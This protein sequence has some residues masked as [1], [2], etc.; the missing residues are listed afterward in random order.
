M[1]II[2]RLGIMHLESLFQIKRGNCQLRS[3][4]IDRFID[5]NPNTVAYRNSFY[6]RTI[7]EWN[8]LPNIVFHTGKTSLHVFKQETIISFSLDLK[9]HSVWDYWILVMIYIYSTNIDCTF[10]YTVIVRFFDSPLFTFC[11]AVIGYPLSRTPPYA[12]D[13][14]LMFFITQLR[15]VCLVS[16]RF[17]L[18]RH[19][20]M[21][22]PRTEHSMV[23]LKKGYARNILAK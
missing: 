23:S 7:K 12:I 20:Q 21:N 4:H 18:V 19:F 13:V 3:F 5:L 15:C 17:A 6:C 11:L 9:Q 14:D 10:L 16:S 8:S 2:I 1:G 22:R